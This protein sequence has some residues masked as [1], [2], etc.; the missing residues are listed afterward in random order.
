MNSLN[1]TVYQ[2]RRVIDP[3]YRDGESPPYLVATADTVALDAAL[4]T[5]D[6]QEFR[7]LARTF[8]RGEST[9]VRALGN[10]L[11]D[12]VNGE[13]L[14]ELVYEDWANSFRMSVHA[15]VRQVLMRFTEDPWIVAY[16]DLALRAATKLS[17]L[18]PYDEKAQLGIA[19]SLQSMGREKR[20]E[21]P[22]VA[23]WAVSM[24]I[25]AR[26]P[27][28]ISLHSQPLASHLTSL[29]AVK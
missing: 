22:F 24:R 26:H 9:D 7:L 17:D 23:S 8:E 4:V 25:L 6:L 11:V 28:L 5:T 1:Q 16:P 18:D 10:D 29:P 19:L 20:Q 12:L 3:G 2:L 14:A 27:R 21:S 15:E 13:F